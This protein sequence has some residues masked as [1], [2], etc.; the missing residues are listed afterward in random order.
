MRLGISI[1]TDLVAFFRKKRYYC[2]GLIIEEM[3][4]NYYLAIKVGFDSKFKSRHCSHLF[5]V[6]FYHHD[7]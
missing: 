2:L 5:F 1:L 7:D 4:R 3:I 6:K